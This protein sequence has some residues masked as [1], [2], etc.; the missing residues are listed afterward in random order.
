M[1]VVVG[2]SFRPVTKVYYFDPGL[3][4]DLAA[5]EYVVVETSQ[6]Q[7]VGQ[8]TWSPRAIADSLLAGEL[9][10]VVR[11]ATAT[12]L[13]ERDHY[14]RR[15]EDVITQ[16]RTK[17]REHKLPMTVVSAEYSYEPSTRASR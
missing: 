6:G 4:L 11:R 14:R 1:P 5:E 15:E 8:V 17:A 3:L 7:E 9:K 13:V 2:V 10:P 12:D 16:C